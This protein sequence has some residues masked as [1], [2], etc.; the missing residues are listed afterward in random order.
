MAEINATGNTAEMA[1]GEQ[2]Q[3]DVFV[4]DVLVF[5]KQLERRWPEPAEILDALR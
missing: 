5:S 3:Y 1:P 4:D 2:S